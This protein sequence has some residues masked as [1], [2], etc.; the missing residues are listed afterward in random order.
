MEDGR[1]GKEAV[2]N[3]RGYDMSY[4]T[5]RQ[6]CSG[7]QGLGTRIQGRDGDHGQNVEAFGLQSWCGA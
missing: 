4:S 5:A 6:A 7:M 2:R 3:L 1:G